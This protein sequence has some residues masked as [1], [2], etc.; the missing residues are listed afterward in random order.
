MYRMKHQQSERI[1]H[2]DNRDVVRYHYEPRTLSP[3]KWNPKD[4][5]LL[6]RPPTIGAKRIRQTPTYESHIFTYQEYD[7]TRPH[8]AAPSE[9]SS[10]KPSENSVRAD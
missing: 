5:V 10:V 6:E 7:H 9:K 2:W 1:G 4:P 8:V 3:T